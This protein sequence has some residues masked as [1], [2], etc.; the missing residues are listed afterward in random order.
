[1]GTREVGA[2]LLKGA[3]RVAEAAFTAIPAGFEVGAF[4]VDQAEFR[5]HKKPGT[6]GEHYA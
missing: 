4:Q 5:G 1:M 6:N 2:G 3:N